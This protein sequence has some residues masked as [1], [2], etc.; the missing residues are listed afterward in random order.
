M[1]KIRYENE[2]KLNQDELVDLL[3][4][5]TLP[6]SKMIISIVSICILMII[7]IF[8]WE[9]DNPGLYIALTVM[10][11]IALVVTVLLIIFKKWLIKVSNKSLSNGVIYNYVFYEDCFTLDSVINDNTS[12]LSMKYDQLEKIVIKDNYAYIYVNNVA[13]YFV[14]MN[15]FDNKEEVIKLFSPYKKRKNK[16]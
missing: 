10:L 1:S 16:R 5:Q 14:N 6:I 2:T 8:N 12:H 3:A 11:S 9:N 7:L 4:E 15:N 13:I